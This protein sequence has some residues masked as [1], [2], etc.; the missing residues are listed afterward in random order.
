MGTID[1]SEPNL[2]Q[3]TIVSTGEQLADSCLLKRLPN[4]VELG[5]Q[6]YKA[7]YQQMQ[8]FQLRRHT[9]T[10]DEIWTLEHEPVFTLGRNAK[11]E[12]ILKPSHIPV[13]RIDRGGQVTYHGPG[14]LIVYT[15]ID[16]KNNKIGV[17]QW[18]NHLEN[19]VIKLLAGYGVKAISDRKAPGVYVS[20]K[21]IAALGLRVS[22][23]C[24][25]HGLSLNVCMDLQP[26]SW[27]NPCGYPDLKVTQ[28]CDLGIK[29]DMGEISN[30][31][32]S[33]LCR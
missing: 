31:L 23:G 9:D 1:G 28:C 2:P 24:C 18:V 21:K 27:I 12:H 25:Y 13:V 11:N 6:P 4:H 29:E 26:F 16:L 7:I 3:S 8:E 14:Q 33:L 20:G 15:L 32:I 5:L 17:R 22:K 19:S 10:P 30:R